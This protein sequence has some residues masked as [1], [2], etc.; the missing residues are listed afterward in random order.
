M[1]SSQI[2]IKGGTI[3]KFKS[4]IITQ[5][6]DIYCPQKKLKLENELL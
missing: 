1:V 6:E 2:E 3:R 4:R 5:F